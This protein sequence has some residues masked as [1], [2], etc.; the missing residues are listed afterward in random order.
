MDDVLI[1]GYGPVGQTLAILLAQQ[2]LH[3][4]VVERFREAYRQPRAVHHDDEIARIFAAAGIGE[5]TA[6]VRE[7]SGDYD[8][9][10][11]D[12]ETLVHFDWSAPGGCGWPR[13]NMFS[14]PGLED[15]LDT[16][17]RS[18]P[19]ITV[20]RGQQV[21]GVSDDG[22]HATAT[23][24]DT[25]GSERTVQA[26]YIVGCDGANS[27]VRDQMGASLHDLGFFYD[28]LILDVVP[29]EQRVFTPYNLQICDPKRP[30]TVVSGGPG[31]RRWEFM[32]LP[33][34]TIEELNTEETAWRLLARWDLTP[35]NA[36]LERHTVYTFQARWADQW[37][38]GRFLLAGDSAHLMPP[39]AG[40]GMCSGIR[41]AMNLSWKLALVIRGQA[42]D[43]LLDTYTSERSAHVQ[44]AIGLSVELGNVICIADPEQAAARD[45]V[46]LK[47]GGRPDLALP[48][49]PPE[50]LG[51][52]VLHAGP[53]D[54]LIP[55]VGQ[56]GTQRA[57]TTAG[58]ATGR[59]DQVVGT[60]FVLTVTGPEVASQLPEDQVAA[61]EA[62]GTQ[63]VILTAPGTTITAP[64]PWQVV[65][66]LEDH[67]LPELAAAGH[68]ALLTRP[69]FYVFGAATSAAE[70]RG[71][72]ADLLTQLE[73][74]TAATV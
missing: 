62:L 19:S 10:N 6:A 3:V 39:F 30:T 71:I 13:A 41:D 20:H 56:L 53:D 22:D 70:L 65:T 47:A 27:F 35:A 43:T 36:D 31:R 33:T 2:G 49:L 7:I 68:V 67:Y 12:G 23:V 54:V 17:V 18:L 34:E 45:A 16:R 74:R 38:T 15:V 42:P 50:I 44:H 14:Q 32:R 11:A 59:F 72:V 55:P 24:R 37:R 69:D 73:V 9:Q 61:L 8:W 26:Q 25:D 51:P 4:R 40:Q 5:E 48:P 52:G 28:W 66:D 29:H 60:G 21:V 57:V 63:L 58:G 46:M 1:V 64:A